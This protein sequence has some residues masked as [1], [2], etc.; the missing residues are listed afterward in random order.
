MQQLEGQHRKAESETLAG[1]KDPVE[2]DVAAA[3]K[4]EVARY[5]GH[6]RRVGGLGSL[7]MVYRG[8]RMVAVDP[9]WHVANSP[10]NQDLAP[11]PDQ[12]HLESDN[13]DALLRLYQSLHSL[14]E[15]TKFR[16]AL[17]LRLSKDSEYAPVGYL[18][19]LVLLKVGR[20][21]E[22]LA[23]AQERLLGD[24]EYGYDDVL[25]LLDGLLYYRHPDFSTEQ[26]GTIEAFAGNGGGFAESIRTR[27][28]AI[29]TLRI[30]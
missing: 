29:R 4:S 8:T 3:L 15:K 16:R 17:L 14:D 11:D 5:R 25:R 6:G 24:A 1:I 7:T 23:T 9:G 21:D 13:H 22:A 10:S 2:K 30:G 19:V 12:A 28:A 27:T 20:L 18:V 26:L